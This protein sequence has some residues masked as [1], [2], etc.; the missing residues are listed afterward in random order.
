MGGNNSINLIV[1]LGGGL[2]EILSVSLK[3]QTFFSYKAG[4]GVAGSGVWDLAQNLTIQPESSSLRVGC[5]EGAELGESDL[6][7]DLQA[8][9]FPGPK[10]F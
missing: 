3:R 4:W 10:G 8:V 2:N 6:T 9:F 5:S 7:G 1:L